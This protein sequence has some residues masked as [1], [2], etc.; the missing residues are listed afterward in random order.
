LAA[1]AARRGPAQKRPT[2]QSPDQQRLWKQ[3]T[4]LAIFAPESS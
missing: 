2:A 1:K 3:T 4:R